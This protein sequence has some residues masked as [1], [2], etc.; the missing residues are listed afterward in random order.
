MLLSNLV[1][2]QSTY[3]YSF[4]NNEII[5]SSTDTVHTLYYVDGVANYSIESKDFILI[6]TDNSEIETVSG[7][8]HYTVMINNNKTF[9]ITFNGIGLFILY[10]DNEYVSHEIIEL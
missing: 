5:L 3:T 7:R 1:T 8:Y 10:K 6:D 2:A 9:Y 4:T